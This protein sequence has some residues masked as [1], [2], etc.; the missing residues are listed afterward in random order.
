MFNIT[1]G[2]REFEISIHLGRELVRMRATWIDKDKGPQKAVMAGV[3]A[4]PD[5][6]LAWVRRT[7]HAL[8]CHVQHESGEAVEL[9]WT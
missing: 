4:K 8:A 7:A 5:D 9:A 6:L 2:P 1:K 3:A